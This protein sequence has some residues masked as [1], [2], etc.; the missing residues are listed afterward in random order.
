MDWTL[1]SLSLNRTS[2]PRSRSISRFGSIDSGILND[3]EFTHIFTDG[4]E[5]T[6][7]V[8]VKVPTEVDE[9]SSGGMLSQC[10]LD[11]LFEKIQLVR[12]Y[13]SVDSVLSVHYM[14]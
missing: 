1:R 14:P 4:N 6:L 13:V 10:D 9:A 11:E 7:R 3:G 8:K 5:A 12:L 2:T